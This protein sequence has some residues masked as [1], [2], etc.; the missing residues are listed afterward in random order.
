MITLRDG[1]EIAID[2]TEVNV[3]DDS[4]VILILPGLTGSSQSEYIKCLV[5]ACGKFGARVAVFNNRGLGGV[6]L[7]V[8]RYQQSGRS[9]VF[10]FFYNFFNQISRL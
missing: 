10:F 3:S 8:M 6:A 1:G 4:P 5:K 9:K 2:W 7:K